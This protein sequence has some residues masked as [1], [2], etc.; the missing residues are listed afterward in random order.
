MAD[1]D[2][3]L[4]IT[5]STKQAS[6]AVKDFSNKST[7]NIDSVDKAFAKLRNIAIAAV[8]AI[9]TG[10]LVSFLKDATAAASEQEK[11]VNS[12]NV[13]LAS[14]GRF[15]EE[16]SR[17]FQN[18]ASRM[19]DVNAVG[20]EV[21]LSQIAIASNF[22]KSNEQ[23]EKLVEAA[24]ELSAATG[25]SLD[26]AVKNLGKTFSGLAGE[27]G[28]SLPAL[29]GL[30]KEALKSGAALDLI[31]ERFG[32]VAAAK[33]NTF[34]G[35]TRQLGNTWGDFTEILGDNIIKNKVVIEIIKRLSVTI[36]EMAEFVVENRAAI[37]AWINKGIKV[38]ISFLPKLVTGFELVLIAVKAVT[39]G[40]VFITTVVENGIKVFSNLGDVLDD[41]VSVAF[42]TVL[43]A[44]NKALSGFLNFV[45]SVPGA[46]TAFAAVGIDIEKVLGR[47]DERIDRF[48][49]DTVKTF[50]ELGNKLDLDNP[51]EAV[52]GVEDVFEGIDSATQLAK[53][54]MERFS[55]AINLVGDIQE[56]TSRRAIES[57]NEQQAATE[58][59]LSLEEK[60]KQIA[61]GIANPILTPDQAKDIFTEIDFAEGSKLPGFI[62]QLAGLFSNILK[63]AEGAVN[64]ISTTLGTI[65]DTILPGIGGVVT[66]I[67]KVL[68]QGPEKVKEFVTQF[69]DAIPE[70][71]VNI[72]E[73]IPVII[74]VL[75]DKLPDIIER[76]VTKL[77]EIA[78]RIIEKT[79]VA[80]SR[81][82]LT[83]GPQLI[84]RVLQIA[85]E[86]WLPEFLRGVLGAVAVI[87]TAA[88]TFVDQILGGAVRFI[89]ELIK[90]A[91]SFVE[92]MVAGIG[93][94]VSGLFGEG[95]KVLESIL[96][97]F[98]SAAQQLIEGAGSFVG[99]ILEGAGRFVQQI[100]D[101]IRGGLENA[102]N[103]GG[104][105][106]GIPGLITVG[107]SEGLKIGNDNT[108]ISIGGSGGGSLGV[109]GSIAGINFSFAEGGLV[110][111]G[112]PNDSA[113]AALSSGEL[114]IPR[115]DVVRLNRFLDQQE[116][117]SVA[118]SGS[119]KSEPMVVNLIVG[120][121][122]L[123]SVMLDLNRR[124]FRTV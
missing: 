90:G 72:V 20:D 41:I 91:V 65:A 37:V 82:L 78:P 81:L 63:G 33:V 35:A 124:G 116:S 44:A 120:E 87:G 100:I 34:E 99:E 49:A 45:A 13:A 93:E 115:D 30:S 16:A 36:K 67:T 69:L 88:L 17:N 106:V 2:V 47:T 23:A 122:E 29:R 5:A 22:A 74:E 38:L 9:T 48:T 46:S 3:N 113:I 73:A 84:I 25:I 102:L 108:G 71:I 58:K 27:L 89:D 24:I 56:D 57:L 43:I 107:G 18:F 77:F 21:V 86:K 32:G 98:G 75:A 83:T 70:I 39:Q 66:E 110:P 7:K 68:S 26:G 62:G 79:I 94:A 95:G 114:V 61:E 109:S 64:V 53:N 92:G 59:L 60:R 8:A 121:K 52:A 42:N 51:F 76:L 80:S 101:E 1:A 14:A 6:D 11:A 19:Q 119:R 112:F 12:L 10:K 55:D 96:G 97:A 111:E 118:G 104:G 50:D 31:L 103:P 123:A 15:S 105:G 40:L 117:N 85:L 4:N 28:E 54:S